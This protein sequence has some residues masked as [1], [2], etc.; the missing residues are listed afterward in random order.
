MPM[1]RQITITAH[2]TLVVLLMILISDAE[3]AAWH[4]AFV[5]AGVAMVATAL[6]DGLMSG[7]GP[8][9]QGAFRRLHPWFNRAMYALL[10]TVTAAAI[11][12]QVTGA[13]PW[14]PMKTW[15]LL[16]TAAMSFHAVFHLWRHTTLNDGAL[17]RITPRNFHNIL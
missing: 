15:Y 14:I 7:P 5:L 13:P 4:W 6:V 8:K 16:L 1:R 3:A 17:R 2:W 10:A 11:A 12:T 9:L